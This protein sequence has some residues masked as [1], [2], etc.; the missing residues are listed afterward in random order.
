L[1]VV[2]GGYR[3]GPLLKKTGAGVANNDLTSWATQAAYNFFFS[4]FPFL[5]LIGSLLGLLANGQQTASWVIARMEG[6]LPTEAQPLIRGVIRDVLLSKN[7]PGLLSLGAILTAWSG[8]TVFRSLMDALNHAYV[9]NETRPWWRRAL[10]SLA[11]LVGAGILVIIAST[12]MLAGPDIASS[13]GRHLHWP[14]AFALLVLVLFLIYRFLPNVRQNVA[15]I[16]VGSCVAALLWIGIT[17][18]FRLYV[19]HFTSY[20][21]TYGSLGAVMVVLSWMYFSML[22]I[23]IGGQLN[24]EINRG[25]GA[26]N[27]RKG[28]VYAGRIITEA[29][30]S[31]SSTDRITPL[32]PRAASAKHDGDATAR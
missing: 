6:A 31:R 9:V 8:G 28:A 2:I 24:A 18:L 27:P 13:V 21:K 1:L 29:Q 30:P 17:L 23:L 3:I 4:I 7:A 11:F 12:I 16:L 22:V 26:V 20:N 5:L 10:M 32:A 14:I 15:Q 19:A 25:T